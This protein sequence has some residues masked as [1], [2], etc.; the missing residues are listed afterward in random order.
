MLCTKDIGQDVQ[1]RIINTCQK[2]SHPL[3]QHCYVLALRH[4]SRPEAAVSLPVG[5]C[6]W[7]RWRRAFG[8]R[9]SWAKAPGPGE[10]LGA[11]EGPLQRGSSKSDSSN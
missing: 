5:R 8:V 10:V 3:S 11:M 4:I 1:A 2:H 6:Q 9:P 7:R